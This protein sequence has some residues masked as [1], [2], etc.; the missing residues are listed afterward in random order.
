MVTDRL[1]FSHRSCMISSYFQYYKL[2]IRAARA[3][4]LIRLIMSCAP[5][6]DDFSQREEGEKE[7][8]RP[9]WKS[10]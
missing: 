5:K 3:P 10:V 2:L 6:K 4:K 8:Q 1:L 7:K 9:T